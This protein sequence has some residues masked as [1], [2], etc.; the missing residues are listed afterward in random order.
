MDGR[1]GWKI[2]SATAAV[3]LYIY[4]WF[5]SF[6]SMDHVSR[7]LRLGLP[8]L[9][10][11]GIW[12]VLMGNVKIP[13]ILV[14]MGN[15]TYSVYIVEFFSTKIYKQIA[16]AFQLGMVMEMILFPVMVLV[17]FLV[18]YISYLVIEKWLTQILLKYLVYSRVNK[19]TE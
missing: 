13:V 3:S 6:G 18:S 17:T 4:L 5:D 9:A 16:A 14:T 7:C 11:C 8:A 10:F 2:L 12:I 19:N 15:M 1:N